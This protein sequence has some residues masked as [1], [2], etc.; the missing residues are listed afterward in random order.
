MGDF[1]YFNVFIKST[2]FQLFKSNFNTFVKASA[3]TTPLDTGVANLLGLNIS[4]T[5]KTA[6]NNPKTANKSPKI[7]NKNPKTANNAFEPNKTHSKPHVVSNDKKDPKVG[8]ISGTIEYI[9]STLIA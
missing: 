5:D 7:A 9:K 4:K 8:T 3:P 2:F 1:I 6:N